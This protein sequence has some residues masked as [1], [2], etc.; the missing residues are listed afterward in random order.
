MPAAVTTAATVV[1][2]A[3]SVG[4][5]LIGAVGLWTPR[6]TL[7]FGIPGTRIADPGFRAW[8]AVKADRD[9]GAGLLVIV[10]LLG[11]ATHLRGWMM[12]AGSLM[13]LGDAIVVRRSG[14]P[15]KAYLGVHG[16]TAAFMVASG[17]VLLLS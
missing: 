9:I 13:A 7:G 15:A 8:L 5:M 2:W 6:I 17:I 16:S 3:V 12:L 11:G 14:G 1:A 4:I 10:V